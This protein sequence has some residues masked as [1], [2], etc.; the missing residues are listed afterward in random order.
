[1]P[2]TWLTNRPYGSLLGQKVTPVDS[3]GIYGSRAALL[4]ILRL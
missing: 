3:V 4:L 2:K 1:M